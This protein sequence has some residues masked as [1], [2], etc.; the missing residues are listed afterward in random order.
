MPYLTPTVLPEPASERGLKMRKRC[1]YLI[2]L[3]GSLTILPWLATPTLA[4]THYVSKTGSNTPPYTSWATATDTV[5]RAIEVADEGDTVR[6]GAGSY[7][8]DSVSLKR[9]MSFLGSGGTAHS[10]NTWAHLIGS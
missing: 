10:F 3:L 5:I 4:D 1:T 8:C 9:R 6:V 2:S 7:T